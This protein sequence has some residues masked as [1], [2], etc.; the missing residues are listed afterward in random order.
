MLSVRYILPAASAA[1]AIAYL[2]AG[3]QLRSVVGD[4]IGPRLFPLVIGCG[5]L[6]SAFVLLLERPAEAHDVTA[7]SR[8][9]PAPGSNDER[10]ARLLLLGIAA[11]TVLYAFVF[12]PLGYVPATLAYMLGLLIYFNRGRWLMNLLVAS[13]FAACAYVLFARLLGVALPR[14]LLGM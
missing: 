1:L 9:E 2:T 14:G 3:S 10:E 5:L 12:E 4:P 13:G 11:W 8:A 7:A 6:V